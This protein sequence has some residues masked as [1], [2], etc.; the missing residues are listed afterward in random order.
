MGRPG[1][2]QSAVVVVASDDGRREV[3]DSDVIHGQ[4]PRRP[5]LLTA[6]TI[7]QPDWNAPCATP[8]VFSLAVLLAA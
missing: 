3:M 6:I 8:I 4:P 5:E 7:E 1:K 2:R